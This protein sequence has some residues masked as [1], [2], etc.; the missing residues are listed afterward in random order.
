MENIVFVTGCHLARS[1]ANI[2]F[3]ENRE[4][5]QVSF[6]VRVSNVSCV[7]WRFSLEDAQGVALNVG[8]SGQVRSPVLPISTDTQEA[9]GQT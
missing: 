2:A 8:P 6:E 3:L 9:L 1:F 7:E 4:E 5:E